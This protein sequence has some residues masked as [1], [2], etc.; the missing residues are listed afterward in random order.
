MKIANC[1]YRVSVKGL[2]L[3][4]NKK[5]LLSLEDSGF[6]NLPGG[7]VDFGETLEETFKRELREEMGLIVTNVADKPEY[8]ITA[9]GLKGYWFLHLV[10]KIEVENLKIINSNECV[11]Y[12]FFSK[13]EALTKNLYPNIKLIIEKFDE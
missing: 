2:I 5:F 7:G 6:W 12:G 1:F 11:E 4:K 8:I 10:Y 9:N 3:D 13:T